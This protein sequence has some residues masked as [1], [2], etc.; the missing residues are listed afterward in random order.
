MLAQNFKTAEELEIN[1][2]EQSAL[3]AVMR[4]FERGDIKR[5]QFHMLNVESHCGTRACI[6][7]WA[8]RVGGNHLFS[9]FVSANPELYNGLFMF[10]DPRRFDENDPDN[11]AAAIRS[12]LTTGRAR[13]DLA[14]AYP[15]V[16]E[17]E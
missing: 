4:M 16:T 15:Q 8:L 1:L 11:A 13:W 12:Y 9:A 2:E 14:T 5:S 17:H 10:G 6:L 7:G 3:I